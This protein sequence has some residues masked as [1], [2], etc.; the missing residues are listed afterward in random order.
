MKTTTHIGSV[1]DTMKDQPKRFGE[2]LKCGEE[3]YTSF[4]YA[5]GDYFLRRMYPTENRVQVR[6]YARVKSSMERSRE[7]WNWFKLEMLEFEK[8]L[9]A[10]CNSLDDQERFQAYKTAILQHLDS[11]GIEQSFFTF[12]RTSKIKA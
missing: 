5:A 7:Y 2:W 1:R 3:A 10:E 8:Q 11:D 6:M 12:L 4:I 9:M